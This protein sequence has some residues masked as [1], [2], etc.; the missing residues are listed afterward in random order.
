[1]VI[2]NNIGDYIKSVRKEKKI[3]SR[4]LAE[5]SQVSQAYISQLET[6]KHSSPSPD[7]LERIAKALEIPYLL[8]MEK[9]GYTKESD[10]M[11]ILHTQLVALEETRDYKNAKIEFLRL[12]A[13]RS[14]I[15]EERRKFLKD[16]LK[17]HDEEM[18]KIGRAITS[19][20]ELINDLKS[21]EINNISVEESK[22]IQNTIASFAGKA[23][24]V[25]ELENLFNMA[26]EIT[27]NGKV[28]TD[29]EKQKALQILKLT[30][31]K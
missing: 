1:M 13:S 12:D 26:Q 2:I 30:F 31:D 24:G 6:G 18:E 9:A 17:K 22:Q 3:T 20:T 25:L 23:N 5:L 10:R 8:L 29:D 21:N 27:I 19:L 15:D 4:K 7:V 28:L 11:E 16:Q 14:D